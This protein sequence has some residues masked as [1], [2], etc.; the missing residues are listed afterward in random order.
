MPKFL[1]KFGIELAVGLFLTAVWLAV[2][3][4]FFFNPASFEALWQDPVAVALYLAGIFAP[5][6]CIWLGVIGYAQRRLQRR[7]ELLSYDT[8]HAE[9]WAGKAVSWVSNSKRRCSRRWA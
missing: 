3:I 9:E 2:A 4:P 5:I 6:A 7:F 8:A 1:Q